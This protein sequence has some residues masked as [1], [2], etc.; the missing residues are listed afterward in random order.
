MYDDNG[1]GLAAPQVGINYRLMVFNPEVNS[2]NLLLCHLKGWLKTGKLRF[3]LFNKMNVG[4]YIKV[5]NE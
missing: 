2:P 3:L 4:R 5:E 1:C